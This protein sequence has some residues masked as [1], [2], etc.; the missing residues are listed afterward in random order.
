[1]CPA[2]AGIGLK[3][4]VHHLPLLSQIVQVM[5]VVIGFQQILIARKTAQRLLH[6]QHAHHDAEGHAVLVHG[7]ILHA[8]D[9]GHDGRVELRD[10]KRIVQ[11]FLRKAIDPAY[12]GR[13]PNG[14]KCAAA[15]RPLIVIHNGR[16]ASDRRL[17]GDQQRLQELFQGQPLFH[18]C[19][20]HASDHGGAGMGPGHVMAVVD[21]VGVGR[22]THGSRC[23]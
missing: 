16:A 22:V 13:C 15:V 2:A 11:L 3:I 20:Q 1:M 19:C 21:I 18:G 9:P 17:I 8:A 12:T 14:A 7:G 23:A 10:R 5:L 6:S 4:Q